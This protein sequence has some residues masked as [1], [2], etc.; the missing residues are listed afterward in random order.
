M[1]MKT[2]TARG[3]RVQQLKELARV[4]A[5]GIDS[6]DDPKALPAMAKQY[7]ETIREIEDLEGGAQDGDEIGD[8]LAER[9]ADGKPGAVRTH[10]T[11]PP[12]N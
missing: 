6:C 8:L 9:R 7:R 10:R 3:S 11:G 12:G 5:G 2:V 1:K 4:L